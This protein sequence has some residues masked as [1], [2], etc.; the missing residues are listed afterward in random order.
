MDGGGGGW[1]HAYCMP[2]AQGVA[3][4]VTTPRNVLKFRWSEMASGPP[5]GWN[6]SL[7]IKKLSTLKSLGGLGGGV[8]GHPPPRLSMKP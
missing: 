4:G 1:Q 6:L 5:K 3:C 8:P 7:S 2:T